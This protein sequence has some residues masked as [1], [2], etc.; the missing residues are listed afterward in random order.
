MSA[1]KININLVENSNINSI[2]F[3]NIQFGRV[4]TDHMFI[5]EYKDGKWQDGEIKPF[6]PI[7]LS[8]ATSALHY[9][10]SI[11]EG[12]RC[13]KSENG[14]EILLFR[15]EENW[16]RLNKSAKRMC[17]PEIPE[18][19]F[20]QG[21]ETLLKV[22][23]QWIPTREGS[24]L[25][26][27]PFYFASD[28]FLGV[29]DSENYIFIIYC[30]PVNAYYSNPLRV[31]TEQNYS[32]SAKKGGLGYAKCAG[33]YAGSMYPAKLAKQKGYDQVMWTD[34]ENHQ[35]IEET[36]TTNVF[37][38][39]GGITI[40]PQ[41]SESILPGITRDSIIRYLKD[42]GHVVELSPKKKTIKTV[43]LKGNQENP[44]YR[45]MRQVIANKKRNNGYL[46]DAFQHESYSKIEI[47]VDQMSD[48]FQ[49]RK[50]VAK[51]LA[52]LDSTNRLKSEQGTLLLPVFFSETHSEYF[53]NHN[54][55][56][57]REN[58]L[59]TKITGVGITDGSFTSQLI[60]SYFQ[61][62]NVYNNWLNIAGRDF[63]SPITDRWKTYYNY[64]LEEE[65]QTVGGKFCYKLS[66]EPKR[67]QDLAFSGTMWIT[68]EEYAI[69][70]LDVK[71][72]KSANLNFIEKVNITQEFTQLTDSGSWLA[73]KTRIV[74]DVEEIGNNPGIIA[75]S[76][77]SN[78]NYVV[79]KVKP[80]AFFESKIVLDE[81]ALNSDPNYWN[82]HRADSLTAEEIRV[83]GMIDTIKSLPVVKTYTEI[84]DLIISGYKS[85]G[86]LDIGPPLSLYA[87]NNIEGHRF[88]IGLR[89][90]AK[91][92]KKFFAKGNIAY[93]LGDE[94]FKYGLEAK[95]RVIKKSYTI[96]GAKI[97]KDIEQIGVYSQFNRNNYLFNAFNRWGTLRQPFMMHEQKVFLNT[98]LFKGV[99]QMLSFSRRNLNSLFPFRY[100]KPNRIYTDSSVNVSELIIG[101]RFSFKESNLFNDFDRISVPM[102]NKPVFRIYG[103][104]GFKD[105][106]GGQ[107]NYQK[108]YADIKHN[109]RLG[110][111]GRTNY[112]IRAGFT[113]NIL[114]YP[115]LE[116]LLYI[117]VISKS[118]YA[119]F[120]ISKKVKGALI[121]RLVLLLRSIKLSMDN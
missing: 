25:Y 17:M 111:L 5:V 22:D 73:N 34:A 89:T 49:K 20:N 35:L 118:L 66:F 82:I 117:S 40:T 102:A 91:L 109:F 107:F 47:D 33:N 95:V 110:V 108:F 32:R 114:P 116:G 56:L 65:L 94:E 113:P 8:P 96:F 27:R 101:Y 75:K 100:Y 59:R 92:S 29:K 10:Q 103:I 2:N 7:P 88:N 11:F 53:H 13:Q 44:A 31:W 105:F 54:P 83:Y 69:K 52:G 67:E 16:A 48:K 42:E 97:Y 61:T 106:L 45:V 71:I 77:V 104:F 12:M 26:M 38:Q 23:H 68:S 50:P 36:G 74:L 4:N 79:N 98:D 80:V 28:D 87:F 78:Y 6:G 14:Q 119:A 55:E 30:C 76:Y 64:V 85:I 41:L 37:V 62:Y 90:N 46:L 9:G 81:N 93:G 18:H 60:G 115:L 24:G 43:V 58:I 86:K 51:I 121:L 57:F 72:G 39:I 70:Q 84:V 21:L 63:V 3:D 19:I 15:P 1:F 112:K 120:W 99:R